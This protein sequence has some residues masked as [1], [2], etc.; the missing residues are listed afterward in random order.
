[1]IEKY[2]GEIGIILTICFGIYS[3]WV[4]KKTKKN[5]ALEFK[6]IECYTLFEKDVNR[7]NIK[8]SYNEQ[9]ITN[10]LLLLKGALI[11]IG[12]EDI[13]K[14]RIFK[15]II[16]KCNE[17][18]KWI[19]IKNTSQDINNLTKIE[20]LS[21]TEILVEWDLLKSG[22]KIEFESLIELKDKKIDEYIVINEFIN[23]LDFNFRI[24]DLNKINIQK[25]EDPFHESLLIKL[26]KQYIPYVVIL[27]GLSFISSYL[28][29]YPL[30]LNIFKP[31]Y[32]I[33]S[34]KSN[35]EYEIF[36]KKDTLVLLNNKSVKKEI[37]VNDFNNNLKIVKTTVEMESSND[38]ILIFC[39]GLFV[40]IFGLYWAIKKDE[41]L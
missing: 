34:G 36:A 1:M 28:F 21:E 18:F 26:V 22:E 41:F 27:S 38:K 3:I 23:N 13:D 8:L 30:D 33:N 15:P 20:L 9:A 29:N 12:K 10:S 19:E 2:Y 11:N 31:K 17:N 4:Y 14:N 25:E 5:I 7:L 16:I 39:T 32:T 35:D 37:S 40:L 6:N 24:T